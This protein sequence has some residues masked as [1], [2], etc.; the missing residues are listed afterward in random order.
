MCSFLQRNYS[1]QNQSEDE[2]YFQN[3]VQNQSTLVA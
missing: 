2:K 1:D 3:T